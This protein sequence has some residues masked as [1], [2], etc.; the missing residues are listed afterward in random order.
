M[1]F[2]PFSPE[3]Y[4]FTMAVSIE[5]CEKVNLFK[6]S[7]HQRQKHRFMS[8]SPY[9]PVVRLNGLRAYIRTLLYTIL[10]VHIL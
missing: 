3:K 10:R 5:Q 4:L 9:C 1:T 2:E 7:T 8:H 6:P